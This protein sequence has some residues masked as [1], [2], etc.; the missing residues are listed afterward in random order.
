MMRNQILKRMFSLALLAGM[1]SVGTAYSQ[2][3]SAPD[4]ATNRSGTSSDA[5]KSAT[6]TSGASSASATSG[7]SGAGTAMRKA[8]QDMVMDLARANLAEIKAGEMAISKSQNPEVK[9]FAQKMIDDHTSAQKDVEQLAKSK[10]ITL[11]TEVDTKHKT[12]MTAL[13][14]LSPERFDRTYMSQGG[15]SD[16][17][18]TH[19]LVRDMQTKAKDQD[20]K[21]LAAKLQPTIAKHLEM[22][23][24][25]KDSKADTKGSSSQGGG[26]GSGSR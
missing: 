5:G 6:G 17:K 10:G 8:D 15:V 21:A 4:A 18:K 19:K 16:H 14:K 11:P 12:M 22:A 7:T 24:G 13:D 9:A 23:Q 2:T 20:V 26:A 3:S 1:F 25:I